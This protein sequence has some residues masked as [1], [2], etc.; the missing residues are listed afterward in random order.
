MMRRSDFLKHVVVFL[1]VSCF[2]GCS[3]P[4]R[5]LIDAGNEQKAQ[6]ECVARQRTRFEALLR[7][8]KRE[9]LLP[10]LREER[11]L[12]RYGDPVLREGRVFLYRDPVDFFGSP[13]VY[14]AFDEA[15]I[16]SSIEVITNESE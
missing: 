13:K 10:G 14:L 7:D 5:T 11:V 2:C 3:Q 4:L 15:G 8:I 9:R 1:A 16:L 12:A 6:G